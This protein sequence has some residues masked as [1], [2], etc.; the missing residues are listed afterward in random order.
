GGGAGRRPVRRLARTRLARGRAVYVSLRNRPGGTTP[1]PGATAGRVSG[2]VLLLGTVSL[3]T[4]VSSEMVA[5]VLPIYLTVAVALSPLAYG[6]LDGLYQAAS[7]VVRIAGGYVG[8][9][10][11][12]PKWVAATGYGVSAASRIALVPA[13]GLAGITAVITVDRLGK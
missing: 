10:L 9:R 7:A 4:D 11:G 2:T 12:R 13:T 6:F 3:L 5:A 1:T 8:D